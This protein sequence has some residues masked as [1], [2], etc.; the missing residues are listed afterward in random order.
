MSSVDKVLGGGP[1]NLS[2]IALLADSKLNNLAAQAGLAQVAGGN[3][4]NAIKDL[5]AEV[6][7]ENEKAAAIEILKIGTRAKAIQLAKIQ[8]IAIKQKEIEVLDKEV[9]D[10][11]RAASYGDNSSNYLPLAMLT[12]ELPPAGV[13][14]DKLTVPKDWVAPAA[15]SSAPA[16]AA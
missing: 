13:D 16:T 4:A 5:Q 10:I 9:S 2:P 14:K 11:S 15:A 3:L 1:V 7:K 8:Q 12:G 6:D